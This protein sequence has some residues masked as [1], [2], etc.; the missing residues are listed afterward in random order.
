MV[1]VTLRV[2]A[3]DKLLDYAA[4]GIGSIA[5]PMLATW[6][7]GREADA[8]RIAARGDADVLGI[9]A[10]GQAGALP[11]ISEAQANARRH[12]A[13]QD[14][15]IAGELEIGEAI[16]QR[17]RFQEEK[18]QRNI[19]AIVSQAATQLAGDEVDDHEPDHDWT[20][21]F[22]SEGQDV[23]SEDMQNLW[24]RVLAG[25]VRR[26]GSTSL[27][28]LTTLKNLDQRTAAI[29]RRFCSLR[30]AVQDGSGNVVDARVCSLG[31]HAGQ[32]AVE[33]YGL[34]FD[35][36]NALNESSL[37]IP[38]YNSSMD[39]NP[40]V[41]LYSLQSVGDLDPEN[42]WCIP[43]DFQN[44]YWILMPTRDRQAAQEFRVQGV[45][46]TRA[47]IELSSVVD[48]GPDRGYGVALTEY[49]LE[50]GFQM[51]EVETSAPRLATLHVQVE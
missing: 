2:P 32:N 11:V 51:V 33:V 28:T 39:Y 15:T 23:S 8:K 35:S 42:N 7:A 37:V 46:L 16:E 29:F 9:L 19:G 24:A 21:R 44:K 3:L 10:G 13:G 5:G 22:F 12:L 25:E 41:G 1:E 4:S 43:F 47:G 50:Q 45:A 17:V 49:F 20:A 26:R 48:P 40:S 6:R 31:R 38:D 14:V 18:R 30:I 34:S 27:R 36:I